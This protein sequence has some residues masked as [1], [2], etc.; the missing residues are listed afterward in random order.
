M[1]SQNIIP[2]ELSRDFYLD[3][4]VNVPG[5]NIHRLTQA[6]WWYCNIDGVILVEKCS[7]HGTGWHIR[8]TDGAALKFSEPHDNLP[9]N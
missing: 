7:F 4:K 5:S 8:K 6:I 9:T 2:V 3:L 1:R